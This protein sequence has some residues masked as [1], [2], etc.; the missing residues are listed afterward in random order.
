MCTFDGFKN[1]AIFTCFVIIIFVNIFIIII[2]FIAICEADPRWDIVH[3][4]SLA[5]SLVLSLIIIIVI[6]FIN[7][8]NCE[9]GS[10]IKTVIST[11]T[12]FSN[13]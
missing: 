4:S 3:V 10:P 8:I 5:L 11:Q 12:P 7:F 6:E 1:A 13:L 2:I 9:A